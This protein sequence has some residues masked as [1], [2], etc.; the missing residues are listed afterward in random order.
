VRI[1]RLEES[2]AVLRGLFADGALTFEGAHY[3]IDG[4]DGMPKPVQ[5]PHP[6]FLVGGGGR[7]ILGVAAR[8]AQIVGINA[9][10]R[11]G[12]G[13]SPDAARSL[14][15]AA[16]DEKVAWVREAAGARFDDLELQTLVGFVHLTDDRTAIADGIASAFDAEPADALHSPVVLVGTHDEMVDELEWRRDRWGLSYH[17]VGVEAIDAFAPVVERLAG[18]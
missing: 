16:T 17:V 14:A 18:R 5:R 4:L 10:L 6:P 2:I 12:D 13:T 15:P 8:D 3:R 9:N 7:R 1:A 11:S